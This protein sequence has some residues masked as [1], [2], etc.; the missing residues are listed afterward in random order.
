M[1]LLKNMHK[2]I[3]LRI[4]LSQ[5]AFFESEF[6]GTPEEAVEEHN[7]ILQLY[8]GGFG[9]ETKEWNSALDEMLNTGSL[10]NG[11]ELY[12][13]MSKDQ[14]LVLQEIKKSFK[15]LNNGV[16]KNT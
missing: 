4:P 15:R 12:A 6:V 11:T 8:N 3:K 5:F 9:L 10:K 2:N 14:Q 7:R 1:N 13:Q 16:H